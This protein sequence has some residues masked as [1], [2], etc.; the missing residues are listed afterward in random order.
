LGYDR[1]TSVLSELKKVSDMAADAIKSFHKPN[2]AN[3][4]NIIHYHQTLHSVAYRFSEGISAIDLLFQQKM[5][6]QI[7]PIIRSLYELFLNFS[8]DWLCP[9]QIGPLLQTLAILNRIPPERSDAIDLRKFID[10]TYG[11]LVGIYGNASTKASLSSLGKDFYEIAYPRL[12]QI[13][14]QDFGVT[15]EYMTTLEIGKPKE[16]DPNDLKLFVRWLD[17][18]VTATVSRILD[19]VGAPLSVA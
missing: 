14:H 18:V 10:E 9:E 12:S 13:V 11:G 3:D 1:V 15:H 7:R 5:V 4:H 16:L 8:I 19:D 17:I 2:D 6:H